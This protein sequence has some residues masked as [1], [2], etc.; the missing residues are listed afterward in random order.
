MAEPGSLAEPRSGRGR[1]LMYHV[2]L[3]LASIAMLYPLL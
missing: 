2:I 1:S 3:C